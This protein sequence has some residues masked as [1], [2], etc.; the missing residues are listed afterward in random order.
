AVWGVDVFA[1]EVADVPSVI[2]PEVVAVAITEILAA[3][4]PEMGAH[5]P[6]LARISRMIAISCGFSP[7]S[8]RGLR[9]SEQ[10]PGARLVSSILR[11]TASVRSDRSDW[12]FVRE[13][14]ALASYHRRQIN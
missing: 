4:G 8:R 11:S 14:S 12:P 5:T 13:T 10:N 6:S 9:A 7:R 2:G 3:P 1:M